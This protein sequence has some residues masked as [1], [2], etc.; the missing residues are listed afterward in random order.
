MYGGYIVF[1]VGMIW[2]VVWCFI[3][4]FSS[5]Y[6]MLIV[7]RAMQGLGV[8]AHLPAGIMLL[9]RVYRPGPRKNR[10]FSL[11]GAV[12]PIGF[13]LG[14]FMGGL[15]EETLSWRW[16]FWLGTIP[17][18]FACV[19]SALTIPRD[20]SAARAACVR[21]DWWG[22]G[23]LIPGLLL[24]VYAITDSSRAVRGWTSPSILASAIAGILLL[25]L[26]FYVEG[27]VS[28][29]PLIP[30]DLFREKYM[31]RMTVCLLVTYGV[32][33]IYLFYATF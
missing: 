8:A 3:A 21:M 25:C 10:A 24:L 9:G 27:W 11:Y 4:G 22:T 19:S 32:F 18:V 7:C 5:N 12:C 16:Y 30:P 23:T 2:F 6:P 26:T 31:K 15:A 1:N 29:S 33:G 20:L 14:M 13:F 28:R 17:C